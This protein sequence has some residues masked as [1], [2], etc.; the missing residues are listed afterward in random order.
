MSLIGS[1]EPRTYVRGSLLLSYIP[2]KAQLVSP[3][4]TGHYSPS[5]QNVRDLSNPPP[6]LFVIWYNLYSTS[7]AFMDIDGNEIKNMNQ[8]FPKLDVGLSYDVKAFAST[9]MIFWASD[10]I[11]FLGNA[12]YMGGVSLN[13][14]SGFCVGN[15]VW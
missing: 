10:K 12:N 7:D 2:S 11:P 6:G 13:G 3:L 8:V 4:Q 1:K 14:A 5:V 15:P 9:P